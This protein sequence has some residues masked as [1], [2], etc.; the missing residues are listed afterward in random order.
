MTEAELEDIIEH[1]IVVL[2]EKARTIAK[3]RG[4]GVYNSYALTLQR[5]GGVLTR[6]IFNAAVVELSSQGFFERPESE[7]ASVGNTIVSCCPAIPKS[8]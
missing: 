3:H 2:R 4:L 6:P 7:R 8:S 1:D 5:M